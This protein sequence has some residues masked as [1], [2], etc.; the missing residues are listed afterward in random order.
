MRRDSPPPGSPL[1]DSPRPDAPLL[2]TGVHSGPGSP[3]HGA[4]PQRAT[5][6]RLPAQSPRTGARRPTWVSWRSPAPP[7]LSSGPAF[8]AALD[9]EQLRARPGGSDPPGRLQPTGTQSH[10]PTWPLFLQDGFCPHVPSVQ[11]EAG[12]KAERGQQ[13]KTH[14]AP[15][16]PSPWRARCC[17]EKFSHFELGWGGDARCGLGASM[18]R[19]GREGAESGPGCDSAAPT[20]TAPQGRGGEGLPTRLP[21]R[22]PPPRAPR[23]RPTNC[24]TGSSRKRDVTGLTSASPS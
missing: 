21:W 19:L 4:D 8:C 24:R 2:Q 7:S 11:V 20:L 18:K 17:Q 10:D 16:D 13:G 22:P 12:N 15:R 5:A 14:R 3:R 6:P 23:R 1:Q 9:S